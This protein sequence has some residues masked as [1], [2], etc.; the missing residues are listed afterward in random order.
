MKILKEA[1]L[2]KDRGGCSYLINPRAFWEGNPKQEDCTFYV[3][4]G[5]KGSTEAKEAAFLSI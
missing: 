1:G 5:I 3:E 2:I 4:F